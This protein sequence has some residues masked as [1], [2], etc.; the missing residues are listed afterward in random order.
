MNNSI[1]G[2]Q[3]QALLTTSLLFAFTP[4]LA[5]GERDQSAGQRAA[6]DLQCLAFEQRDCGC[7]LK[8]VNLSCSPSHATGWEAQFFS[9]LHDGA[10]LWMNVA[11]RQFSLRSERPVT[12]SFRHGRR[13]RW[14]ENYRGDDFTVRID[15]RPGK[16][17]CPPE[18]EADDGCEYFDVA[19]DIV[20]TGAAAGAGSRSYRA[21]GACGC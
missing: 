20:V 13:D 3:V 2:T 1:A 14:R 12:N 15:Y 16:S 9:E 7:S 10:P 4:A 6:L 18:K 21:I 8:V 19:A 17:T 11:G 5:T